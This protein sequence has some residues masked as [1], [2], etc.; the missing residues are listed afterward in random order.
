ML[1]INGIF[2][3]LTNISIFKCYVFQSH[4]MIVLVSCHRIDCH[5]IESGPYLLFF[6]IS[7]TFSWYYNIKYSFS[8]K[9]KRNIFCLPKFYVSTQIGIENKRARFNI[10]V[11]QVVFL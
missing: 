5:G 3:K 9:E 11:T 2:F 4:I 10:R 6:Q 1:L 7:K 8:S